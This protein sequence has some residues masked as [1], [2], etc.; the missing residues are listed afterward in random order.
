MVGGEAA[1][2]PGSTTGDY[3]D[4]MPSSAELTR[5]STQRI[6]VVP[7][8]VTLAVWPLRQAPLGSLLVLAIG[9]AA[10]WLAAWSLAQPWAGFVAAGALAMTT[11][12]TWIPVTYEMGLAGVTQTALGR[13]RRISWPAIRGY[14]VYPRGVLLLADETIAP[15]SPLRG[16][17]VPWLNK[18]E[19]VLA[20]L[21]Y[22]LPGRER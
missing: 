18:R 6:R 2:A 17:Y 13:R 15:L 4:W 19:A 22:H 8:E 12:R 1:C 10:S 7:A 5:E 20:T 11:W 3:A 16:L 9:A 14:R 21:D